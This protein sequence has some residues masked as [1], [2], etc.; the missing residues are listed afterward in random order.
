[1]GKIF[2]ARVPPEMMPRTEWGNIFFARVPPEMMPRTEWKPYFF[3][4][5]CQGSPC[6]LG[7]VVGGGL[8]AQPGGMDFVEVATEH[9]EPK[10]HIVLDRRVGV[11]PQPCIRC[12][13]SLVGEVLQDILDVGPFGL[14]GPHL[15]QLARFLGGRWGGQRHHVQ[16]H[17]TRGVEQYPRTNQPQRSRQGG[18]HCHRSRSWS[19]SP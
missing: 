14:I 15:G 1:M 16:E 2:F 11:I 3:I 13:E 4:R 10:M 17:R 18:H 7:G 8:L 9:S 6:N 5:V 12:V 19:P